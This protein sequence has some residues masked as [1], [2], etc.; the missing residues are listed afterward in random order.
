[1]LKEYYLSLGDKISSNELSIQI[2]FSKP[3]F[4][5]LLKVASYASAIKSFSNKLDGFDI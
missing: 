4:L 1:M 2:F 5:S 3:L